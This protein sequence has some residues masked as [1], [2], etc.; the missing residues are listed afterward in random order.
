MEPRYT[1]RLALVQGLA[2]A[3]VLVIA[4]VGSVLQLSNAAHNPFIYFRF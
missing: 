4:L 3:V 1:G 2:G